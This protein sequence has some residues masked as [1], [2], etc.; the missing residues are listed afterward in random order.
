M[1]VENKHKL[2]FQPNI[3]E[4][5]LKKVTIYHAQKREVETPCKRGHLVNKNN[6]PETRRSGHNFTKLKKLDLYKKVF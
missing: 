1:N 5:F 4:A 2:S 6:S 3:F